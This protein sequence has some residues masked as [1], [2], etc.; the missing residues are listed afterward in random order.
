N[1]EDW[2]S[3]FQSEQKTPMGLPVSFEQIMKRTLYLL[4][5]RLL[6]K[7]CALLIHSD[8]EQP[9]RVRFKKERLRK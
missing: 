8:T 2:F 6:D 7:H 9:S 4:L 1:P 3:I 5:T